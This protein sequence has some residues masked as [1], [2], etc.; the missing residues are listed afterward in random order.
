MGSESAVSTEGKAWYPG[1]QNGPTWL[2]LMQ[3][4][5]PNYLEGRSH[6]ARSAGPQAS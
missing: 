6:A 3:R 5:Q 4:M 1:I 2:H